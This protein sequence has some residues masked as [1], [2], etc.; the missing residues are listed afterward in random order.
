M[1]SDSVQPWFWLTGAVRVLAVA[2]PKVE[3][4]VAALEAATVAQ[5]AAQPVAQ[6]AALL[7][8]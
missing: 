4:V 7:A 3:Q 6:P 5:P 1:A 2:L 8:A